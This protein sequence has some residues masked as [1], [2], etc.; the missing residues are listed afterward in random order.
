MVN[1][2]EKYMKKKSP[3][4]YFPFKA[5]LY[6][7]FSYMARLSFSQFDMVTNLNSVRLLLLRRICF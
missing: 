5:I 2:D 1:E 3:K 6:F 7:H 4:D